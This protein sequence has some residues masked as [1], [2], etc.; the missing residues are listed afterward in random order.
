METSVLTAK[1]QIVVPARIR[2]RLGLTRG[3]KVAFIE[4]EHGFSVRPVNKKYFDRYAG[5]L[6]SK[7]KATKVLLEERRKDRAREDVRSR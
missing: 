4:E 5:M 3:M 6:P 1:G 2:R 7:G